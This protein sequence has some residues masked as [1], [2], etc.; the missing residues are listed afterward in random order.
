LWPAIDNRST[1]KLVGVGGNLA[2]GL[3]IGVERV[4][5]AGVRAQS[6]SGW[7]CRPLLACMMLTNRARGDGRPQVIAIG[8]PCC[9][10]QMG[11]P[12]AQAFGKRQGAGIAGCSIQ[13]VM[14]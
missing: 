11:D 13:V 12:C 7:I 5:L 8:G 10:R 1:P 4:A 3:R 9:R 2:D 6:R 14:M